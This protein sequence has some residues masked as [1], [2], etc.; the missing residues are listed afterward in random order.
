[1]LILY[2]KLGGEKVVDLGNSWNLALHDEFQKEYYIKLKAFLLDEY[3]TKTIYPDIR[4]VFNALKMTSFE[5]VKVVILGQDPYHEPNQAHGLAF[6]VQD[7]IDFPA[8][9]K[10]I[11]KELESDLG[12]PVPKS[13]NLS[14]W[15]KQGV[16]LLNTVLT[17]R[18]HQAG[19]HRGHGWEEFTTSIIKKLN[20]REKPIIFVLWGNDAKKKTEFITSPNHY[21]LKAAHPSPLSA[22]NGFFGCHHFSKINE[23]LR[24]NN[25]K[26]IEWNPD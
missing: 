22:Y 3:K 11:F 24:N 1:M 9:L 18:A 19:S 20:E 2:F 10:N 17:V 25:E 8:S 21:I 15:A 26:E 12:I 13:G 14:K 16:L 5:D 6:S 7:G 4:N 23:I